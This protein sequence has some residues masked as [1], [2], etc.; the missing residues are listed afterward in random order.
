M[1][2][3]DEATAL[4]GAAGDPVRRGRTHDSYWTFI[5]PFGGA[6]AAIALRAV[7]E[8]PRR[9]GDPLAATVNFCVPIE[10]GEF[11][12]HVRLARANRSSQHWLVE[13]RQGDGEDAALT[14]SIVT[15]ARR[16]SWRHQPARA[17]ALPPPETMSPFDNRRALAWVAQYGF[18]FAEGLFAPSEGIPE[19][20][21]LPRSVLWLQD[22]EPRKLDFVSLLAMSDAFFGRLFQVIG[23]IPPFGTVSMTTYFHAAA[24]ELAAQGCAPLAAV[25]DARVFHRS[26]GDQ[27]AELYGSSGQLLA[28]S[29]QIA[30]FRV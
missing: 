8:H 18:R 7:L 12:V 4:T 9:E 17:P 16:Q 15:A 10:R 6:S 28:T 30:Y 20:P 5:G 25:A 3:L 14:A 11:A 26:F 21:R 27:T 1:H 2:P 24:D 22:E 29:V 13:F 19:P 23:R